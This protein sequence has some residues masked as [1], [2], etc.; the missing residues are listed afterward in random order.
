MRRLRGTG[1][2]QSRRDWL[3]IGV[4][5]GLAI[6]VAG[7]GMRVQPELIFDDALTRTVFILLAALTVPHM[8]LIDYMMGRKNAVA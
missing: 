7:L 5:S 2:V 4:F 6:A 1:I 3:T 8:L